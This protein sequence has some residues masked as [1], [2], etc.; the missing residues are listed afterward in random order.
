MTDP[1]SFSPDG[2]ALD[3]QRIVERYDERLAKHGPTIEALAAGTRERQFLRFDVLRAIGDLRSRSVLDLG[4]GFG[5]LLNFLAE[6]EIEVSEYWG[7][8]INPKLL[9]RAREVH[10][11][12]RFECRD[13][14]REPPDEGS[15]DYVLSSSAFNNAFGH[16]DN[17]EV[18]REVL[19]VCHRA[20]RR[21]VAIN[22]MTDYVDFR[23]PEAFYYSPER[24]FSI[25]KSLCRRV[26]LRHDYPLFDFTIY[27]YT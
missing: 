8:D 15:V 16:A 21:G 23:S 5:D 4:C 13:I 24:I 18:V 17:Y 25:A 20:A 1:S 27:L 6:Q 10:V 2:Y 19:R 3:Q 14:L 12:R 26:T 22:L 7:I 9:E 11:G